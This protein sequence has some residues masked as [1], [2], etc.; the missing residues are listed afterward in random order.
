MDCE[1]HPCAKYSSYSQLLITA[2]KKKT[3]QNKPR[4]ENGYE[5]KKREVKLYRTEK[6]QILNRS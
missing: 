1:I 6:N 3:N 2:E 4:N 5:K